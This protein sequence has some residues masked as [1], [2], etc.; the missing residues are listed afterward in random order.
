MGVNCIK[1]RG[2]AEATCAQLNAQGVC[3]DNHLKLYALSM[4]VKVYS[5]M[6]E[7]GTDLVTL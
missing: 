3:I 6:L 5:N 7:V 4:N 2:E 1:G